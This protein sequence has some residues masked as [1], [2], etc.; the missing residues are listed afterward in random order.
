MT[1]K[2]DT[3]K[4]IDGLLNELEEDDGGPLVPCP[5]CGRSFKADSRVPSWDFEWF[6]P[7]SHSCH[8]FTY[9]HDKHVKKRPKNSGHR[10]DEPSI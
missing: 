7:E 10:F 8:G 2:K 1:P 9:S 3:S 5:D 4:S 6:G